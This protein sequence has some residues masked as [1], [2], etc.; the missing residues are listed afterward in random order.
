MAWINCKWTI[1]YWARLDRDTPLTDRALYCASLHET[2]YSTR[3]W[4]NKWI[5]VLC[6]RLD[7]AQL[8][9]RS[10]EKLN[11]TPI[12][13]LHRLIIPCVSSCDQEPFWKSGW[14]YPLAAA[15]AD[16]DVYNAAVKVTGKWVKCF[17]KAKEFT[18]VIGCLSHRVLVDTNY[19][20]NTGWVT[21][22]VPRRH[23]PS[24]LRLSRSSW[25]QKVWKPNVKLSDSLCRRIM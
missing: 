13:Q 9:R 4:K 15:D 6:G 12:A 23:L 14:K 5:Y 22:S 2:V 21:S 7:L 24:V 18:L 3:C 8:H 1:V 11:H 19:A 17:V 10:R 20:P 25:L 16:S